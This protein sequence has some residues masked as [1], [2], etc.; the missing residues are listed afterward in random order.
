MRRPEQN[1]RSAEENIE[2]I[3]DDSMF[4]YHKCPCPIIIEI[5]SLALNRIYH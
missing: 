3:L 5:S 4:N 2:S 1:S